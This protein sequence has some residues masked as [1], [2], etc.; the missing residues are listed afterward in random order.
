MIR[1][2]FPNGLKQEARLLDVVDVAAVSRDHGLKIRQIT[3]VGNFKI[4]IFWKL[5]LASKNFG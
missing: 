2:R 3:L 4:L 5:P 1:V